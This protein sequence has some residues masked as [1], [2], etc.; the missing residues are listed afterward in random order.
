MRSIKRIQ[1]T[2]AFAMMIIL[3]AGIS[4]TSQAALVSITSQNVSHTQSVYFYQSFGPTAGTS[5]G[6]INETVS[7][8]SGAS[9]FSNSWNDSF[10]YGG[11]NVAGNSSVNYAL[12]GDAFSFDASASSSRNGLFNNGGQD[13]TAVARG[14]AFMVVKFSLTEAATVIFN[15]NG[16]A[17]N[18]GQGDGGGPS[19]IASLGVKTGTDPFFGGDIYDTVNSELN[20]F[21]NT[22]GNGA[23]SSTLNYTQTLAAGDYELSASLGTQ[24]AYHQWRAAGLSNTLQEVSLSLDIS[25]AAIASPQP[26]P[27]VGVNAPSTLGLFGLSLFAIWFRLKKQA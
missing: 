21:D 12:A 10:D 15:G 26:Q 27:P 5:Y 18:N 4:G 6:G 14:S 1:I 13:Q 22:I 8:P 17:N 20:I 3:L 23:E 25:F 16:S 9:S 24:N 2:K 11:V 19:L 7:K